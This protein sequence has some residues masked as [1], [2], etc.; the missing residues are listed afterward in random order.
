MDKEQLLKYLDNKKTFGFNVLCKENNI[1]WVILSKRF[2][3]ERFFERFQEIDNPELFAEQMKIK[4]QPYNVWVAEMKKDTYNSDQAPA[5]EDYLINENYNFRTLGEVESFLATLNLD[6][7][8]IKW[9][10]EIKFF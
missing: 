5:S 9:S 2:P 10:S 1:A 7:A 6:L 8:N 4:D 3:V